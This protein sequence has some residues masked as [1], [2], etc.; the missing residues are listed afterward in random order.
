MKVPYFSD[1]LRRIL[2]IRILLLIGVAWITAQCRTPKV[3]YYD[4]GTGQKETIDRKIVTHEIKNPDLKRLLKEYNDT[5][6][7]S[8]VVKDLG[9]SLYCDVYSDSIC[10]SIGYTINISSGTPSIVC[11]P[12]DGKEVTLFLWDLWKDFKLLPARANELLKESNP[13]SYRQNKELEKKTSW[14]K[15]QFIVW[16]DVATSSFPE[17]KVTFDRNQKLLRVD[18]YG[19]ISDK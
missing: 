7:D 13:E 12:I 16:Q 3:V 15:G 4:Y 14:E 18:R 1:M 5:Y 8:S 6:K 2:R 11:E 9:L 19:K 10:Y 17:W